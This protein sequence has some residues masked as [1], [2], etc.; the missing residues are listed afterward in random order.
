MSPSHTASDGAIPSL[1]RPERLGISSS[2]FQL[3][4]PAS[5]FRPGLRA[6]HAGSLSR[7][8]PGQAAH[9]VGVHRIPRTR[10]RTRPLALWRPCTFALPPLA[11]RVPRPA[12]CPVPAPRGAFASGVANLDGFWDTGFSTKETSVVLGGLVYQSILNCRIMRHGHT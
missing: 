6:P 12:G 7:F 9:G 5:V 10:G 1:A 11:P 4:A 8:G 3:T 2:M